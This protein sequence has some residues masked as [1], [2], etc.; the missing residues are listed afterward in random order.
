MRT[1][2]AA[3][4]GARYYQGIAHAL[5]TILREEGARGLYSGLGATLLQ[6]RPEPWVIG[7]KMTCARRARAAFTAAWAPRCCR[8]ARKPM[9]QRGFGGLPCLRLTLHAP[10]GSGVPHRAI[11]EPSRRLAAW[12]PEIAPALFQRGG[13]NGSFCLGGR[14]CDC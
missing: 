14:A 7:K 13:Q 2:L 8:R 3:Q 1:R 5:H 10:L 9:S 6:A 12:A 11:T 4:T